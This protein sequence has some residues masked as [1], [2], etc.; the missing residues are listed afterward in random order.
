M[1]YCLLLFQE[2]KQGREV[3]EGD[4]QGRGKTGLN[5]ESQANQ[6]GME[7]ENLFQN[8]QNNEKTKSKL[9]SQPTDSISQ[10]LSS[11]GR[12]S[13]KGN[14]AFNLHGLVTE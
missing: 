5:S 13:Y 10:D 6:P 7:G 9:F 12:E 4:K 8:K 1:W 3:E 11:M 14:K 2:H